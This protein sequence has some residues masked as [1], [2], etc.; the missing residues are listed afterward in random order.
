MKDKLDQFISN[1]KAEFDDQEVSKNLWDKIESDLAPLKDKN[2]Y[3]WLWKVAAIIFIGATIALTI[4]KFQS[5][6]TNIQY[7][8]YNQELI[9]VELH[10]TN[11]ISL[12]RVE[13]ESQLSEADKVAF[14]TDLK[15]LDDMYAGLKMDLGDNQNNTKLISAMIQNLQI[16]LEILNKQLNILEQ[17]KR[18]EQNETIS[19]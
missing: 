9:D 12:K 14:M 17:I 15:D 16:R 7:A 6:A 5:N 11:Q 8:G 4:D 10:Y 13:L 19:I 3:N 1:N 2:N 18:T